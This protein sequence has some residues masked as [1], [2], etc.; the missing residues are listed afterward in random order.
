MLLIGRGK[1][2]TF[3]WRTK[4]RGDAVKLLQKTW[5]ACQP[6]LSSFRFFM[7]LIVAALVCCLLALITGGEE[8]LFFIVTGMFLTCLV[9]ALVLW[10]VNS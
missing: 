8:Q 5:R 10:D 1:G 4:R 9:C 6:A 7:G 3:P 2:N